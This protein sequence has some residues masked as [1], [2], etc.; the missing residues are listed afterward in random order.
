MAEDESGTKPV[1]P[2][3][4][5]RPSDSAR[6]RS[7]SIATW[8]PMVS[9]TGPPMTYPRTLREAG[10]SAS[11][12]RKV[13]CPFHRANVATRPTRTTSEPAT[14]ICASASRS[15][16]R[17]R[18]REAP[19]IDGVP[20]RVHRR[21]PADLR[22]VLCHA[23]RVGNDG[24]ASARGASQQSGREPPSRG[25][26]MEVPDDRCPTRFR[27]R[28]EQMHLQTVGVD[29]RRSVTTQEVSQTP[30]IE[31]CRCT[32]QNEAHQQ[33]ER[34]PDTVN[35]PITKPGQRRRKREDFDWH[36]HGS[37]LVHERPVRSGDKPERPGRMRVTKT[38]QQFVKR[39]FGPANLA[40][41]REKKDAHRSRCRTTIVSPALTRS[42]G[43]ASN[44]LRLSPTTRTMRRRL[45][46]PRSM[47]PP[48]V[49][50]A[51]RTVMSRSR[52]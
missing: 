12:S 22:C 33:Q 46:D 23:P 15:T 24:C 19:E 44:S 28:P 38:G 48:A 4:G 30:Q 13:S 50:M 43:L 40:G 26:I 14:G 1:K 41:W 9:Y 6:A 31:E 45:F 11:A 47:M 29:D 25:E 51:C 32:C 34:R 10:N 42:V 37:D 5:P 21:V 52:T 3:R 2:T 8:L 18:R 36:A 49:E 16:L 20:D 35:T 7:S 39:G 27:P 17:P